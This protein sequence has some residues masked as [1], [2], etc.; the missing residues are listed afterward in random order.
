[1]SYVLYLRMVKYPYKQH[2][3][4]I[5]FKIQCTKSLLFYKMLS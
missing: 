3:A 2:I 1:M 5:N 4:E